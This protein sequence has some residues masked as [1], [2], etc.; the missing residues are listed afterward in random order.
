MACR[1]RRT[2]APLLAL[3][4]LLALC[5]TACAVGE[6]RSAVESALARLADLLAPRASGADAGAEQPQRPGGGGDS[7]SLQPRQRPRARRPG[8]AEDGSSPQRQQPEAPADESAAPEADGASAPKDGTQRAHGGA[9]GGARRRQ[10]DAG[11]PVLPG[12]DGDSLPSSCQPGRVR[13]PRPSPSVASR[14]ATPGRRPNFLVIITDDQGWDDL[15]AHNP[16]YVNTPHMDRFLARGTLFDSYYVAPQ[17]AQSRASLLTGRAHPRTGTMLVHAGYDFV[18]SNETQAAALLGAA[19]YATLHVGKWH[20]GEVVGYQPTDVGFDESWYPPSMRREAR[21]V[22]RDGQYEGVSGKGMLE[23]YLNSKLLSYLEDRAAEPE[24]PFFAF[25]APHAIHLAR[26][27]AGRVG[28]NGAPGERRFRTFPARFRR[29]YQT[30]PRYRGI[31]N[32]TLES[33]AQLEYLDELLGRLFTYL[34]SSLLGRDT[35]VLLMSD[36]GPML[37]PDEEEGRGKEIRMPS[38]MQGYKHVVY[39][40]GIRNFLA[41]RGPGV[42]RGVVDS[43]LLHISDVLPTLAALAGVSDPNAGTPL[44]WDGLSFANLLRPHAAAGGVAAAA[45]L[46]GRRGTALATD[47]QRE[48]FVV[49]LS[50]HC[51]DSDAVPELDANREVLRPQRLF[52]YDSGGV[53]N[54]IYA[55]WLPGLDAPHPGFEPCIGVHWRDFKFVGLTKKVYRLSGDSRVEL[56]CN[57]VPGAQGA[58]LGAAMAAA[59]RRWWAGVLASPHSFAKPTFPL[60]LGA[61]LATNMLADGAHE[62]TPGRVTIFPNG[63]RGMAQPGD[64][65]CWR[66]RVVSAGNYGVVV[67]YTSDVAATFKLSLGPHADIAAGAAPA[68]YA[69]LPATRVMRGWSFG[70]MALPATPPGGAAEACLELVS[71]VSP[72]QPVFTNLAN[73]RWTRRT[74]AAPSEAPGP[75]G[76]AAASAGGGAAAGAPRGAAGGVAA[77]AGPAR[78]LNISAPEL[79]WLRELLPRRRGAAAGGGDAGAPAPEDWAE[80]RRSMGW[81][82]G[83]EVLEDMYSPFHAEDTMECAEC[84]PELAGAASSGRAARAP[85]PAGVPPPSDVQ[86]TV[87]LVPKQKGTALARRDAAPA[88][89]VN[90]FFV[91]CKLAWNLFF[92]PQQAEAAAPPN[93]SPKELGKQRLQ[94]ILVADRCGLSANSL[95]D[96]QRNTLAALADT[97]DLEDLAD[98]QLRFTMTRESGTTYSL[99]VPIL[100]D[101]V[102]HGPYTDAGDVQ[103]QAGQADSGDRARKMGAM[104][105][106]A[107]AATGGGLDAFP[108]EPPGEPAPR[109]D[110]AGLEDVAAAELDAWVEGGSWDGERAGEGAEAFEEEAFEEEEPL[111]VAYEVTGGEPGAWAAAADEEELRAELKAALVEELAQDMQ[112][113]RPVAAAQEGAAGLD[114]AGLR[115]AAAHELERLVGT[116]SQGLPCGWGPAQTP[117]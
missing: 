9:G 95:V 23:D 21:L 109:R 78:D 6:Q 61:S 46:D 11:R 110:G 34:E 44:A 76:G 40:G 59:A 36:N 43:T 10:R 60:G 70:W 85:P 112:A 29:R 90:S 56:A 16:G 69:T 102:Q 5:G 58:A 48:R 24:T 67:M 54:T 13:A 19:G 45:P 39:E 52:D 106:A 68:L 49:S 62:R 31:A 65:L 55:K 89:G 15:G 12:F 2:A 30:E 1:G 38:R 86:A 83:Q 7:S 28:T 75:E 94:M 42:A 114:E 82:E 17:C 91:K 71:S 113:A 50:P 57:E 105:A 3:I 100:R 93:L 73:L 79:A 107:V 72:G 84:W 101:G 63:V 66:A 25:Y 98:A 64:R 14:A 8:R 26:E 37:L 32:S 99:A 97:M 47:A 4:A 41:V 117:E 111:D 27:P 116:G 96:M 77:A 22:R 81:V 20:N 87:M 88:Q 92:P 103:G 115:E 80:L 18:H 108:G 33:W 104:V 51:W 74:A 35:Y 53:R